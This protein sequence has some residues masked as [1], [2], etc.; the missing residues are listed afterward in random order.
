MNMK[1][2]ALIRV[3]PALPAVDLL[4][5]LG[6]PVERLWRRAGLPPA[7]HLAPERLVPFN[8]VR[9]FLELTAAEEGL[10]D[11][12]VRLAHRSGLAGIGA[13]GRSIVRAPTLHAALEAARYGVVRH[14]SS[15]QYWTIVQG[16]TVRL[17]RRFAGNE[18]DCRQIDLQ[19]VILMIELVRA[20]A[21]EDWRPERIEFQSTGAAGLDGTAAFEKA[22]IDVGRPVTSITFPRFLLARA[23][24]RPATATPGTDGDL[25]SALP[26]DF[27][28]S[29]E[30]VITNLLETERLEIEAA[31]N[32]AGVSVRTLQRR[33][34]D[35]GASF[36]ELV[37]RVRFRIATDLL[38]DD[39]V[40]I[41]DIALAAGYSDP[42]HFTRAFRRWTSLTPLEYRRTERD[43]TIARATA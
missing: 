39:A 40:K 12:G 43:A 36:S 6:V 14:N 8:A 21:G 3:G 18:R 33:L 28:A 22:T 37:D 13:F 2:I 30:V 20:V 19:T 11:L 15:A 5:D 31:S 17:C 38:R 1:P 10:D 35:L 24:P 27:L 42:A 34:T 41:I 9:E 26:A 16:D 7:A 23:M 25:G 4:L 32:A 29:L